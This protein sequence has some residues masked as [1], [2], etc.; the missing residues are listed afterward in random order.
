MPSTL[1][2]YIDLPFT[3]GQP[4]P[5]DAKQVHYLANVMRRSTGDR[6]L[7]FN[8][9]DGEWQAEISTLTKRAGSLSLK[10]Q[11]RPI[12]VSPDLWL[13]FAPIKR[14]PID[15]VAE[16]AAELG[17]SRLQPVVTERTNAARVNVDRLRAIAIEA[18]EQCGRLSVPEICPTE[19][20]SQVLQDWPAERGLVL[21]N[22]SGAG[23]PVGEVMAARRGSNP[24]AILIGPEGGFSPDELDAM[25]NLPFVTSASM[26][27]RLLRAE[28]A[29]V[30]ALAVWQALA[31]DWID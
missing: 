25:A 26:G 2:L 13:L 1:R 31:G 19:K 24:D 8:G 30:A 22:E 28:T 15:M 10:E 21:M 27:S 5:L 17:V 29:A 12:G 16:K 3:L 18:A 4:L 14:G 23:R 9:R 6:V 20:L 11:I 7:V